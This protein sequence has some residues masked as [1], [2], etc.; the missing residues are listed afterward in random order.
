VV[1]TFSL[2]LLQRLKGNWYQISGSPFATWRLPSGLIWVL[3]AAGFSLLAPVDAISLVG[4]NLLVV[5]L[6]LYFFQGMA[7]VN[8]FLRKKTYPPLVKGLIY[9]LLLIFNPLPIIITCVGVF[10]L[11][12]DF[13]RPRQKK[14]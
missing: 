7:I 1:Q 8:N 10:D 6:P 2:L 14:I 5:L 4:R 11:W 12:I 3:I 13:R 9:L